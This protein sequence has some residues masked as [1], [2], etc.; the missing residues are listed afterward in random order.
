M[1]SYDVAIIG[2]GPAGYVAAIRA[3]QLGLKTAVVE[4]RKSLG[5]TCLNIGC[6]PSKT[7]LDSSELFARAKNEAADHGIEIGSLELNLAKMMERKE[8]VVAKLTGGVKS[9]MKGNGV[10]VFYGTAWIVDPHTIEVRDES[11][12]PVETVETGKLVLANGSVP[13]ELP[14]LPFDGEQVVSSTEALSFDSV[15]GELLVVG[16]GAIGLEMASVW[17][18]LGAKVTVVEI[19]PEI[20]P[21]WDAQVAKTMR[22]ELSK[23]GITFEVKTK[24]TGVKKNK[25]SVR[26]I[27]END[28][29]EEVSYSGDKILVAVGRR[30]YFEGCNIDSL[31]LALDENGRH[32]TVNRRFE[33]SQT[34]VYAIGD[35]VRGPMLAHKA[36]DEGVAVA[37][38]LAGKPGHVNYDVIPNVVYTWPEA[39]SVGQSE[40]QLEEAGVPFKKGSF[41]FAANGR[42]LAMDTTGGFVKILAHQ[43]SDRVLGMHVVGPWASDLIAEAAAVMEFGGSA[44]DM[45][46]TCHA[47]PTLPEA[48]KEA[49]LAVAGRAIHTK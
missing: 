36:E 1:S 42:A 5:G 34:D 47:H 15:P 38:I 29:G 7:L 2:A 40:E 48:V 24:V 16:A 12:S 32:I 3:A 19:M 8:K 31:S 49:A 23:Q 30:A 17:S 26:L 35:I 10:D 43:E 37:E 11:G 18:R 9:L 46:R 20:L 28:K 13:V 41:P 14:F 6:I 25:K 21:G 22:R 27:A 39:A 33:T 44:E 45:A 4:K